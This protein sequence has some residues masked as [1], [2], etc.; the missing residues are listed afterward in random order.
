MTR[1]AVHYEV[2]ENVATIVLDDPAA[3][4]ALTRRMVD[5][6]RRALTRGAQ[7]ARAV[8]LRGANGNFCAGA[9]LSEDDGMDRP[10][11]D[12]GRILIDH[13]N[14]LMRVVRDLAV[15]LVVSLDGPV[16]GVGA[17]IALAGDL[18]FAADDA[19]L[20]LPFSRI[21]LI[22]DGGVVH[23]LVR[24]VGR[25]RAVRIMLS[26]E[27][28]PAGRAFDLGLVTALSDH[29]GVHRDARDAAMALAQGPTAALGAIRRLAW[30]SLDES[31]ENQLA[32]EVAVQ[33]DLALRA[34]YREGVSAF[35]EK[36]DAVFDG[37]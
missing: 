7:E 1:G 23:A 35:L 4:N 9:N 5:D 3:R 19:F 24:A 32:T 13:Y 26:A 20:M 15:P 10:D 12:G 18:I 36:R 30:T 21:G 8:H 31:F 6:L 29:H 27:R 34:D 28:I 37:R 11:A 14:P 2:A 22:P 33:R 17:S 25:A 16:V